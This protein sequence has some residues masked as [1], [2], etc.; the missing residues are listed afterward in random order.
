[1]D[2]RGVRAAA[3][4]IALLYTSVEMDSQTSVGPDSDTQ[5]SVGT[6]GMD[7]D[8]GSF[9]NEATSAAPNPESTSEPTAPRVR[10]PTMQKMDEIPVVTDGT[11]E[12]VR[13]SFRA[14]LERYVLCLTQF[15]GG[16]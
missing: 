12:R 2:P 4:D 14:F 9:A 3:R 15:F 16:Y 10:P 13:E 5:P 1:M 7:M 11:G 6:P 8:S